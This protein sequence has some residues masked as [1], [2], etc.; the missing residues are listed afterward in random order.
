MGF[1]PICSQLLWPGESGSLIDE[2]CIMCEPSEPE[3]GTSHKETLQSENRERLF[4]RKSQG[5]V[6]S[7]KMTEWWG[8][9]NTFHFQGKAPGH[10]EEYLIRQ[11]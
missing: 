3:N 8:R 6:T 10:R 9:K 2:V 4:T 7:R 1:M 5:D 11:L